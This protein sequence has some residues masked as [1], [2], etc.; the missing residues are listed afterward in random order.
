MRSPVVSEKDLVLPAVLLIG[1]AKGGRLT[2]TQLIASLTQT[3]NPIGDASTI[4]DGRSDTKFSQLVRNLKSHGTLVKQGLAT[5]VGDK[6]EYYQLTKQGKA[7]HA[8]LKS[9]AGAMT[10]K[11]LK[12]LA[13]MG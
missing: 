5:Y 9:M 12:A 8:G 7:V 3:F 1:N 4:L 2:S 6:G 11:A 13:A 10:P